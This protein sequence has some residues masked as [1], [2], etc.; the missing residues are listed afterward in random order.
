MVGLSE[1]SNLNL[2][3]YMTI[4]LLFSY[5]VWSKFLNK[6]EFRFN[7]D[8][9]LEI[10]ALFFIFFP[11]F[12]G[13]FIVISFIIVTL[14][15]IHGNLQQLVWE[16]SASS[17]VLFVIF[18]LYMFIITFANKKRSGDDLKNIMG[19]ILSIYL[20]FILSM[21]TILGGVHII[22]PYG[23][24]SKLFIFGLSLLVF[25]MLLSWLLIKTTFK[26]GIMRTITKKFIK[27]TVYLIAIVL[28]L[29]YVLTPSIKYEDSVELEYVV[30]DSSAY[31]REVYLKERVPIKIRNFGTFGLF[32][33][34]V[35]QVPL[36]YGKYGIDV[37]NSTPSQNFNILINK[38]DSESSLVR[39]ME[40]IKKYSGGNDKNFGF[41]SIDLYNSGGFMLLRFENGSINQ[42]NIDYIILEGYRRQ[43]ITEENYSVTDNVKPGVCD[44]K[45]CLL[46]I[47]V[48]NTLNLP[49]S[50]DMHRV[51]NLKQYGVND[52]K[53]C[54]FI[55][56][57][58][59]LEGK[60]YNCDSNSCDFNIR[61]KEVGKNEFEIDLFI[62]N[63]IVR[64]QQLKATKPID[65]N[66]EYGIKC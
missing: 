20:I 65:I 27:Q 32:G 5:I 48:N 54:E 30:Y 25:F 34:L 59:S 52:T 38:T 39:G 36:Y 4:T 12:M 21:A 60:S 64:I 66:L 61:H 15:G 7:V 47:E 23:Y 19:F 49:V 31:S 58:P 9:L 63:E 40:A 33:S 57:N 42:E 2:P 22:G 62:S 41:I 3:L 53:S 11:L 10:T 50:Q 14:L 24:L 1:I 13:S 8:G 6:N 56:V 18:S 45:E 26:T 51:L 28:F 29:T 35:K 55:W 46:K 37:D 44:E 43:D 17:V 16:S